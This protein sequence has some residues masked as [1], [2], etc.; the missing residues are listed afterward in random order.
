M[1][2]QQDNL[3]SLR[4]S[5]DD[6]QRTV[7]CLIRFDPTADR[8]PFENI[9]ISA[10]DQQNN[11]ALERFDLEAPPRKQLEAMHDLRIEGNQ[12]DSTLAASRIRDFFLA[13]T[14]RQKLREVVR[15]GLD[16]DLHTFVEEELLTDCYP[17]T[18][19][20][21]E[22]NLDEI[23]PESRA[24]VLEE[25]ESSDE[26]SG[27]LP[28][29]DPALPDTMEIVPNIKPTRGVR[30]CQLEPGDYLEVRVVG[31]GVEF[32]NEKYVEDERGGKQR[33]SIPINAQLIE[34]S[35]GSIPQEVEFTVHLGEGIVGKGVTSREARVL[36]NQDLIDVEK[37]P[38]LLSLQ[39]LLITATVLLILSLIY[40]LWTI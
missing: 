7:V 18:T 14:H 21:A 35:M 11:G 17:G 36:T 3:L 27:T 1:S 9:L 40:L 25:S 32:L 38:V 8:Q 37:S 34:L 31:S 15:T 33:T 10:R 6:Y 2:Y 13:G 20:E 29:H 30:F 12:Q 39:I 23:P 26:D 19:L 28:P 4:A 24:E 22:V 16:E 5:V